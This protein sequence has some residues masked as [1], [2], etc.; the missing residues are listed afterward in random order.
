MV[1]YIIKAITG[2]PTIAE[3]V[4]NLTAVAL[5]AVEVLVP[6][7]AWCSGLKDPALP[8]LRHRSQ[9]PLKLNPWPGNFHMPWWPFKKKKI[10]V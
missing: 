1:F 8:Q 10:E 9:L 3:R 5:V 6:S 4:E 7:L 2:I